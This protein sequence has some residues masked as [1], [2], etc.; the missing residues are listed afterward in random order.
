MKAHQHVEADTSCWAISIPVVPRGLRRNCHAV[1]ARHVSGKTTVSRVVAK[2]SVVQHAQRKPRYV[3]VKG[4]GGGCPNS[5]FHVAITM[6][7]AKLNYGVSRVGRGV[8]TPEIAATT[9]LL[10]STTAGGD[11]RNKVIQSI[12]DIKPTVLSQYTR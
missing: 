5:G 12:K 1:S 4:A 3:Q 7:G 2:R 6:S 9:K 8:A 11:H 10:L